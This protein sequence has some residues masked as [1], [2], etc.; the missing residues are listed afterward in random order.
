MSSI[1]KKN[2]SIHFMLHPAVQAGWVYHLRSCCL[3]LTVLFFAFLSLEQLWF[4]I[5]SLSLLPIGVLCLFFTFELM[6]ENDIIHRQSS[7]HFLPCFFPL[8]LSLGR[9]CNNNEC[10]DLVLILK[11]EMWQWVEFGSISQFRTQ[12]FAV[13]VSD[14]VVPFCHVSNGEESYLPQCGTTD[15][16]M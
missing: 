7:T 3:S 12:M 10:W 6:W 5:S 15:P 9:M 14:C 1:R 13:S 11:E 8:L 16:V 2:C 4:L